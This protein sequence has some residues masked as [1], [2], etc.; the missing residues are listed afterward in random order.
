MEAD[1]GFDPV[2]RGFRF[3]N[4]FSGADVI[5]ELADTGRLDELVGLDLP[6]GLEGVVGRIR[7]AGFWGAFETVVDYR[8]YR[9]SVI[10]PHRFLL[11]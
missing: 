5:D 7:D 3:R 6:I 1:T 11:V 2:A 8:K 4:S 9:G 10:R